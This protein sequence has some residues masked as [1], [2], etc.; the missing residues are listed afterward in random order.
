MLWSA[1]MHFLGGRFN[2]Y[3]GIN[4]SLRIPGAFSPPK[5]DSYAMFVEL[6]NFNNSK[7]Y[8]DVG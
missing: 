7:N 5:K 3:S 1:L 8:I 2:K 6:L 4:W